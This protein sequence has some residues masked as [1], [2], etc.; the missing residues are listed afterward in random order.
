MVNPRKMFSSG[1]TCQIKP[2]FFCHLLSHVR[3]LTEIAFVGA[4]AAS[5]ACGYRL[6][7]QRSESE[8]TVFEKS[9]GVC[10]R[11]ATRRHGDV[12]FDYGA[13]YLKD[14]D[15][16]V[17]ELVTEEVPTDGLEEIRE[18]IWVFDRYG[19]VRRGRDVEETRWVYRD[20]L[21]QIAKRAFDAADAE[22]HRNTRVTSL[23]KTDAGWKLNT[24]DGAEHGVFDA[25]VLNPPAPQTAELLRNTSWSNRVRDRLVEAAFDVPYRTVYTAVLGYSY[26]VDVPYYALVNEDKEH[27]VGW[28]GREECKPGHVPD[29]ESVLVVQANHDWSVR[30]YDAPEG[31]NAELLADHAADLFDDDRLR[32]HVWSHGHGW[33]YALPEEAVDREPFE[34][35]ESQGLYCTGDWMAG[36]PRLHAALADGLQAGDR[37]AKHL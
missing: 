24:E 28:V 1:V 36:E 26:E 11:A 2:P 22:V 12:T 8:L 3:L 16:R 20:G 31:E 25:V 35:A 14:S 27:D 17:N 13:N 34:A 19:E 10:G 18:P 6:R 29:G 9:G 33:R 30:R 15:R 21:T 7:S 5:A 23:T 32:E 4:G 37:L